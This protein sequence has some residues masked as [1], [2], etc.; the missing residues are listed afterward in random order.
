M[1]IVVDDALEVGTVVEGEVVDVVEGEVVDVVDVAEG[2]VEVG[3]VGSD[4]VWTSVEFDVPVEGVVSVV[5]E[6][7][8]LRNDAPIAS[9]TLLSRIAL[10]TMTPW[11]R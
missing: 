8:T 11:P 4:E 6:W 10:G 5:G 3:E 1:G 9:H 7:F 2:E